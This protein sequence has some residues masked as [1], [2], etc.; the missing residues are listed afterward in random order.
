MQSLYG[1]KRASF[2]NLFHGL[3]STFTAFPALRYLLVAEDDI[4][5]SHDTLVYLERCAR[6]MDADH[7][8]ALATTYHLFRLYA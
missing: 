3:N 6:A 2:V 1:T 8:I 5:Y 7:S 4:L